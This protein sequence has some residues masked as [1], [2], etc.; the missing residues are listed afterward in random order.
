MPGRPRPEA[1][2]VAAP[3]EKQQG[4]DGKLGRREVTLVVD[5][6]HPAHREMSDEKVL[7]KREQGEYRAEHEHPDQQAA[8]EIVRARGLRAMSWARKKN[9]A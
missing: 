5:E 1:V 2:P 8:D 3:V 4:A 9:T 7:E 6:R